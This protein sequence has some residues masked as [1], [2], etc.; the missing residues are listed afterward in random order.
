MS[1]TQNALFEMAAAPMPARA[2]GKCS[3][4][5]QGVARESAELDWST[6][7]HDCGR[8]VTLE[9]VQGTV[10]ES[11][12]CDAR[13][14]GAVGPVCSCSCGGRNHGGRWS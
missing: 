1:M 6:V 4:C 3:G 13:C 11:R 14:M 7:V 5:G 12:P 9:R 10:S 8:L 2:I